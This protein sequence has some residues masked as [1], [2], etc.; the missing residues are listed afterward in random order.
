MTRAVARVNYWLVM[1][2]RIWLWWAWTEGRTRICDCGTV[3]AETRDEAERVA[4]MA[5]GGPHAHRAVEMEIRE[6][7]RL[8][9]EPT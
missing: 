5:L 6:I 8:I 2:K 7:G 4:W 3:R 9:E 1:S